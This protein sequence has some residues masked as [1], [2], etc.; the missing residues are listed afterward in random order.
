M[1]EKI[2]QIIKEKKE[3]RTNDLVLALGVTRQYAH[4]ALKSLQEK[5]QIIKI[6]KTR[7]AFYVSPDYAKENIETFDTDYTE[8]YDNIKLSENDILY[9]IKTNFKI[10]SQLPKNSAKVF[11]FAFTEMLNN[12]IEH[13]QAAKISI[14]VGVLLGK[15]SFKITDNGVG[16]FKNVQTN[17]GLSSEL[18][19]LQD[20]TKGKVTTM[21][22]NHTGQG[23]FFT[24]RMVEIFEI[25]SFGYVYTGRSFI[26]ALLYTLQLQ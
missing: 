13:S 6:G 17:K 20:V 21:P 19:A 18:E 15:V 16:I 12:A 26:K 25:D 4:R 3:L 24:S 23:I 10:L 7:Y 8:M 22:K 14:N 1:E 9:S 11:E 5:D 2:K